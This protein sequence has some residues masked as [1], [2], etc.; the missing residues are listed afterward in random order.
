[1]QFIIAA[2][3]GPMLESWRSGLAHVA[4]VDFREG[5]GTDVAHGADAVLLPF[6]LATDRYG[7]KPVIGFAE[8]LS[9]ARNDGYPGKVVTTPPFPAG[10]VVT[11]SDVLC[12]RLFFTFSACFLAVQRHNAV[13]RAERI[14]VLLIHLEGAAI[15]KFPEE[16]AVSAF[17]RAVAAFDIG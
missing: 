10:P 13:S 12:D 11:D 7:G 14:A 1:M 15:I 6:Q 16:V 8:V 5:Y 9:N 17:K 4:G 2:T 3:Q